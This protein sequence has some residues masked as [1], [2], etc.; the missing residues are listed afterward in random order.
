MLNLLWCLALGTVIRAIWEGAGGRVT[1]VSVVL[2]LLE[3]RLPLAIDVSSVR[4]KPLA[5]YRNALLRL[6]PRSDVRRH[7]ALFRN[8]PRVVPPCVSET[9]RGLGLSEDLLVQVVKSLQPP[10]TKKVSSRERQM[11]HFKKLHNLQGRMEKQTE[12]VRKHSEQCQLMVDKLDGL[13]R[14]ETD[15]EAQYRELCAKRLTPSS[16][17]ERSPL[18]SAPRSPAVSVVDHEDL[19]FSDVSGGDESGMD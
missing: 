19:R 11:A 2:L 12:S 18:A 10:A 9:L 15:K 8:R 14:E 1:R 16:S 17:P 3:H 6:N 5:G 4:T 7:L 13:K